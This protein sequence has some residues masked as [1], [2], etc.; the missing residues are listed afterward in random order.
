VWHSVTYVKTVFE[1]RSRVYNAVRYTVFFLVDPDDRVIMESQCTVTALHC[2]LRGLLELLCFTLI[3]LPIDVWCYVTL[4]KL[5]IL[6][7]RLESHVHYTLY[8]PL[9]IL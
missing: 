7:K 1:Q 2:A 4:L 9:Y 5:Y 8:L 6:G 3:S